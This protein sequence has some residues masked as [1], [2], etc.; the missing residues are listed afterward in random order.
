MAKA[1]LVRLDRY[2]GAVSQMWILLSDSCGLYSGIGV[3]GSLRQEG[4]YLQAKWEFY[5]RTGGN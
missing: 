1:G 3:D 2:D 4:I 5:H